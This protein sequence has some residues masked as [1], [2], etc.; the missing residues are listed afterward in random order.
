MKIQIKYCGGCNPSINRKALVNEV[1]EKLKS[2]IDAEIVR[3][4]ADVGLIVGGCSVCCVN[5]DDIRNQ[6]SELV[7]VGGNLVEYIQVSPDQQASEIVK[8]ILRKAE[9][10]VVQM[11]GILQQSNCIRAGSS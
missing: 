8:Q 1:I 9:N 11:A 4:N 2:C 7:I 5:L 3:E 10:K 6:A